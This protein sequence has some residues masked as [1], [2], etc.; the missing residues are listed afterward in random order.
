M[1][2][3]VEVA[4]RTVE[5][6]LDGDSVRVDGVPALAHLEELPGT[7]VVMLTLGDEVHRIV[8]GRGDSRGRYGLSV[9]GRRY[10]VEALD[11][12]TRAIRELSAAVAGPLGPAPLIAPM[13]GLIVRLNGAVGDTVRAGQGLVVMEAMKMENELRTA[14]AGV[15]K[16]I[17][18][19]PGMAVERGT[20][21]VELE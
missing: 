8:V 12:R 3:V 4:G 21:L 20:V 1:K 18:V 5:V 13:P 10:D 16:A 19:E 2:Y 17:R 7:P 6:E 15:I 11:E 14:A 9:A